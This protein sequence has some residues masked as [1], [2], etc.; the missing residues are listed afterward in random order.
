MLDRRISS[1]AGVLAGLSLLA[2]ALGA[3]PPTAPTAPPLSAKAKLG[4]QLFQTTALS[5]PKGQGCISCHDPHAGFADPD[6]ALPTSGGAVDGLFGFR[7]APTISYIIFCPPR[8]RFS[9]EDGGY[10]GGMFIDGRAPSLMSQAQQPFLNPFEMHNLDPATVVHEIAALPLARTFRL[11]YGPHALDPGNEDLAYEQMSE[12]IAEFQFSRQFNRFDSKYDYFL[13]GLAE[14]TPAESR[15]LELF[16]GKANCIPCHPSTVE[17]SLRAPPPHPLFT[18]FGYDNI[19]APKNWEN[20]FLYMPRT[21][22]PDGPDFIDYGLANT[23]ALFDPEHAQ[24]EAGKFKTSTLRNIDLTAPYG[25]NG[26]FKTLKD[27][28]HFYNTRDVPE[29]GWPPPEVPLNVNTEDFG[30]LGL[31]DQEEDDIVAFLKTL[32]DG[33]RP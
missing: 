6:H 5:N 29:A 9:A 20:P 21:I 23:I 14:L 32:T 30:N 16:N 18:D 19:G 3:G 7:N 15:G 17:G 31:T 2:F 13:D 11:V 24:E 22:N 33:Y 10:V 26:Y 25:H 1:T 8:V 27:I 4:Q 28:V 12:A